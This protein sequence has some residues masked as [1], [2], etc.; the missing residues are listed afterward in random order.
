MSCDINTSK[1]KCQVISIHQSQNVRLYQYIITK[2]RKYQ[3]I[4]INVRSES[5][6]ASN[7]FENAP[8]QQKKIIELM[9]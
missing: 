6:K 9:L 1:A 8:T 3:F 7:I 5:I 4:N 2:A